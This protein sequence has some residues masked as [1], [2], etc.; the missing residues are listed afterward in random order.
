MQHH[1]KIYPNRHAAVIAF[2]EFRQRGENSTCTARLSDNKVVSAD[3]Q[4][5]TQFAY[6]SSTLD[7]LKFRGYTLASVF[8]DPAC[9]S[10]VRIEMQR[11]YHS[12]VETP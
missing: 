12:R 11:Q 3:G 7:C 2:D 1:L 4:E 5:T 6:A 9:A 8:V 10:S